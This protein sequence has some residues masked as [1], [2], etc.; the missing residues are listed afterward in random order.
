MEG[1]APVVEANECYE[2]AMAGIG[3]RDGASPLIVGNNC[4]ENK[5]VAIGV[6]EGSRA[7]IVRNRLARTAGVPPIIAVKDD[8]TATILD[9][10]ISGG[11]VAALLIQG[12]VTVRGNT[13]LGGGEKQGKAVWVWENSTVTISGNSFH[14]YGAA[15]NATKATVIVSGNQISRFQGTAIILKDCRSPV[16]VH[17][18]T[19]VAFDRQATVVEVKGASGIVEN[20][21]LKTE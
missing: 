20:N 18:N 4:R 3:C 6:T 7:I 15:V 9:N 5:L 13:F 1:T 2:N 21:S 10:H 16:Y 11:G 12:K 19:A 17:G 8:S 14:G